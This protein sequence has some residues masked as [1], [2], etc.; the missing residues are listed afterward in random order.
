M[1]TRSTPTLPNQKGINGSIL[2][3]SILITAGSVLLCYFQ[4]DLWT[5]RCEHIIPDECEGCSRLELEYKPSTCEASTACSWAAAVYLGVGVMM[6]WIEKHRMAR[7]RDVGSAAERKAMKI[8][9]PPMSV[10]FS[11]EDETPQ[12]EENKIQ[13]V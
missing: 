4:Y 8:S 11:E 10:P 3:A 7:M 12:G 5:G 1:T 13:V 9:M 6:M 2:A